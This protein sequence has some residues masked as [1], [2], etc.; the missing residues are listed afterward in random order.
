MSLVVTAEAL[1]PFRTPFERPAGDP[2][3]LLTPR[4]RT[5]MA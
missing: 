2:A 5:S 1:A 3:P 4:R